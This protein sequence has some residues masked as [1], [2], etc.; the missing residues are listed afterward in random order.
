MIR[1]IFH[2]NALICILKFYGIHCDTI[3]NSIC[4]EAEIRND[5]YEVPIPYQTHFTHVD[6]F[7]FHNNLCPTNDQT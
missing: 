2:V 3:L 7:D 6:S 1:L 4:K 5:V